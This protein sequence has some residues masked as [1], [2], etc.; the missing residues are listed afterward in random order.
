MKSRGS[1]KLL[2]TFL[3]IVSASVAALAQDAGMSD[4]EIMENQGS[5]DEVIFG[6]GEGQKYAPRAAGVM[7][8]KDS[9]TLQMHD[10]PML[11]AAQKPAD[12]T[13]EKQGSKAKDDSILT[14]NFLYYIIQKYKLQDII[15]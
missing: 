10:F 6:S 2:L 13:S 7:L 5:A 11:R 12:K 3:I 8:P 4:T 9:I 15:D 1:Q 14:Y